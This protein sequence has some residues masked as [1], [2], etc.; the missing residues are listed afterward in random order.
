M[1]G[2]HRTPLTTPRKIECVAKALA[3]Q[4]ASGGIAALSR[5]FGISRPTIYAAKEV[6]S[7]V[8]REHFEA[9]GSDRVC[10][11]VDEAQLRRAVVALRVVSP[12]AL[13][14]IED[15]LPILYPGV[16]RSYGLIQRIAA[17]A[18]KAASLYPFT[19]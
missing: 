5:E 19:G 2:L 14:P 4:E 7:E 11:G 16:R 18:E 12:N 3:R 15:L 10:V 6:A 13:R 8:L 17:E 9:T 1:T